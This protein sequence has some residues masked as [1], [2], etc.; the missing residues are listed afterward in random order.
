MNPDNT[1]LI[2]S[3]KKKLNYGKRIYGT[4]IVS[5]SPLWTAAVRQANLDF[6]FLDTEHIPLGRET[7]ANMCALYSAEGIPPMVRIP[8]PDPYTACTALDG[9]ASAILAP[10]VETAEQV[11][12]LVGA[13]KYRPLKGKKLQQILD[14]NEVMDE[15]LKNYIEERCGE[16]LL[17]INV[18]SMPAI[19]NL[20]ELLSVP[21]L[22]GVIIGP[23]DLSCSMG[24]PEE[25]TNP[26]FEDTVT[27]IIN[28]CRQRNLGIG[29]HLSE[30]PEHQV[31]WA[32]AGV[33]IILHSSDVSLFG[34]I[35]DSEISTIKKE[36]RDEP[37]E[38]GDHSITI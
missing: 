20:Q 19:D 29:I 27:G 12:G 26:V 28:E 13:V 6:V 7:V 2:M 16:N 3:L 38:S 15:K 17:F 4:A 1:V 22:D 10:Y 24:V 25:Y 35:L 31:R 33:N 30:A 36:L 37:D 32:K 23:H 34:K 18:E 5:P 14:G 11:K 9:G 21:G 8:S